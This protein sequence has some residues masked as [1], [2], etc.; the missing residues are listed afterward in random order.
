M[1]GGLC[2]ELL[3]GGGGAEGG[4]TASSAATPKYFSPPPLARWCSQ[5]PRARS[6]VS[7]DSKLEI[8][9]PFFPLPRAIIRNYYCLANYWI[10]ID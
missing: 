8:K 10:I 3:R 4:L 2:S 9:A 7:D 6:E 1:R 5:L